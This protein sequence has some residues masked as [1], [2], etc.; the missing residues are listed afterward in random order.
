MEVPMM[1]IYFHVKLGIETEEYMRD[2]QST[3]EVMFIGQHK[4]YDRKL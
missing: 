1:I 2:Q 4:E 3:Y